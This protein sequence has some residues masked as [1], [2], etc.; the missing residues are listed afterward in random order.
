MNLKKLFAITLSST[1]AISSCFINCFG[2]KV[3]DELDLSYGDNDS[4]DVYKD[5]R[6]SPEIIEE[7]SEA[8]YILE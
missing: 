8:D 1:V 4:L 5:N 3:E 7:L 2:S 6:L